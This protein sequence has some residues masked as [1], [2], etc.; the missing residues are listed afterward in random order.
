V[1]RSQVRSPAP[2]SSGGIECHQSKSQVQ[3]QEGESHEVSSLVGCSGVSSSRIADR[4][5]Q[6]TQAI[7]LYT[8]GRRD[9][10]HYIFCLARR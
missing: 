8:R 1:F 9:A 7:N 4:V 10:F 5:E 3:E 2:Q 6:S